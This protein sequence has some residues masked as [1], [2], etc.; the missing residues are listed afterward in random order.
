[1]E[2]QKWSPGELPWLQQL[3][4]RWSH[5]DHGDLDGGLDNLAVMVTELPEWQQSSCSREEGEIQ[6]EQWL[7]E[8]TGTVVRHCS[9]GNDRS[10]NTISLQVYQS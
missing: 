4:K 6:S 7:P 2:S 10:R 3:R 9:G 8:P 1:M 5:R